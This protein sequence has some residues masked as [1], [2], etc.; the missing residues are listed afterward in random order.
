MKKVM[1]ILLL[2]LTLG[3]CTS[4]FA[5]EYYAISDV[6][7][8]A[9]KGWH[10]TYTAFGREIAVN[11][12]LAVPDIASVPI[13]K[14]KYADYPPDITNGTG[15][16]LVYDLA[17]MFA[18]SST[19]LGQGVMMPKV[20]RQSWNP[21]TI[22]TYYPPIPLNMTFSG[23]SLTLGDLCNTIREMLTAIGI[24]SDNFLLD[25]PLN[26]M[27]NEYYD[28][29]KGETMIPAMVVAN[30]YQ[31]LRG[32]PVLLHWNEGYVN[33]PLMGTSTGLGMILSPADQDF[34]VG[35]NAKDEMEEVDSDV[36]LCSFPTVVAA[37]EKEIEDGHIRKVYDLQFG[38]ALCSA[39]EN[40]G[41]KKDV[42]PNDQFYT[43]PIWMANCMYVPSAKK[44]INIYDESYGTDERNKQEY[45][46][47]IVNAQTGELISPMGD[48]KNRGYY[49]GYLSW[50]DVGG[51]Q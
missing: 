12:D 40:G 36:P 10:Q 24:D 29:G 16:T 43:I 42:D 6:R 27:V 8:Q 23:Y 5:E 45:Q 25:E 35:I 46:K 2:F 9:A 37:V 3:G 21:V 32:I 14:C 31:L 18:I 26:L 50:E 51:K 22:T 11:V 4:G 39:V 17:D 48:G 1:S 7:M 19:N 49:D 33:G 38:Y 47:I 34:F 13:I 28:A 15:L 30:F 44:E 41:V 20:E